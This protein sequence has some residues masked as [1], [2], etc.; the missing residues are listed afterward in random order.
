MCLGFLVWGGFFGGD[1]FGFVCLVGFFV[2]W[3]G[4][5][6]S[7]EKGNAAVECSLA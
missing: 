6:S 3:L 1:G 7:V 4:F 5:C 2:G